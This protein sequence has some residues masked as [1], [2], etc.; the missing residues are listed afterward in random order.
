MTIQWYKDIHTHL[1]KRF[2]ACVR[3]TIQLLTEYP[4]I[5]PVVYDN[6]HCAGVN[7][8]PYTIHYLIIIF[9]HIKLSFYEVFSPS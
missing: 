9:V 1:A 8:F 3:Q 7:G 5:K 2:L 6:V 4:E